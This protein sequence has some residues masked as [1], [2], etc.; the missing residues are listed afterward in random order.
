MISQCT[1]VES[2]ESVDGRSYN[3]FTSSS[4]HDEG[5]SSKGTYDAIYV[6]D[7]LGYESNNA[8]VLFTACTSDGDI[9]IRMNRHQFVVGGIAAGL[10]E[11]GK[12]EIT[13]MAFSEEYQANSL[14]L[15]VC[16]RHNVYV[17][18]I[19][20]M[21]NR[22]I[23]LQSPSLPATD[24]GNNNDRHTTLGTV[25][26]DAI[27]IEVFPSTSTGEVVGGSL[28]NVIS[29]CAWWHSRSCRNFALVG[30]DDKIIIVDLLLNLP[31]LSLSLPSPSSRISNIHVLQDR[32]PLTGDA[33][34]QS[35]IFTMDCEEGGGRQ[36]QTLL[37]FEVEGDKTFS[38]IDAPATGY[39][40]HHAVIELSNKFLVTQQV[41]SQGP[42]LSRLE[43]GSSNF[44]LFS[45]LH[46][47]NN[48]LYPLYEY[49]VPPEAEYV[50]RGK[51]FLFV[52]VP[53]KRMVDCCDIL[54]LSNYLALRNI[55][56]NC[57]LDMSQVVFQ[58]MEF[59]DSIVE[60][61]YILPT[62][63]SYPTTDEGRERESC[64]EEVS[65]VQEGGKIFVK[66]KSGAIHLIEEN[67]CSKVV[68]LGDI[69]RRG[70]LREAEQFA[71]SFGLDFHQC[72]SSLLSDGNHFIKSLL[73]DKAVA[74]LLQCPVVHL[75]QH[76]LVVHAF[77]PQLS[78]LSIY[79]LASFL[80][81]ALDIAAINISSP[82]KRM[83]LRLPSTP[84]YLATELLIKVLLYVSSRESSFFDALE[85]NPAEGTTTDTGG[86]LTN[87]LGKEALERVL[88]LC[89][90]DYRIDV[91]STL[92]CQYSNLTASAIAFEAHG[93]LFLGVKTR[94]SE[95]MI[96]RE[97]IDNMES[98]LLSLIRSHIVKLSAE[99]EIILSLCR[100]FVLWKRFNFP[101]GPLEQEILQHKEILGTYVTK[102]LLHNEDID[103]SLM[104]PNDVSDIKSLKAT[105]KFS[106]RFCFTL[107]QSSVRQ[108]TAARHASIHHIK[109]TILQ[110]GTGL[111]G[112][113][114]HDGNGVSANHVSITL[115]E[116]A[117]R[118]AVIFSCGH[119][120][121]CNDFKSYVLFEL[122]PFLKKQRV[123]T[124]ST[125]VIYTSY[126]EVLES[127]DAVVQPLSCPSCTVHLTNQLRGAP[128]V[129]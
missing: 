129:K 116:S 54:I 9:I 108:Y 39:I 103:Y 58:V 53:S 62:S 41:I 14:W 90:S 77:V 7:M 112:D 82:T 81:Q 113:G 55:L 19:L 122:V 106:K 109:D 48:P 12:E 15:L 35:M 86:Q 65:H 49:Q 87:I 56:P 10:T 30:S 105:L 110:D 73:P 2:V 18:P 79:N 32:S 71:L 74:V 102:F 5:V 111:V 36:F 26:A 125:N 37:E 120:F 66:T 46:P 70:S 20:D 98:V 38:S 31:I 92:T 4:Y 17:M 99:C 101:Y 91:V 128:I 97:G 85:C 40:N 69:V 27:C 118:Q 121:N 63:T 126:L 83:Q 72:L 80:A 44:A 127:N 24:G 8:P 75:W 34:W 45:I 96:G 84:K 107:V 94:L 78:P 29:S 21:V 47:Q 64:D 51:Q 76:I 3:I 119:T 16:T 117:L 89:A 1:P 59:N 42:V 68:M 6:Y 57:R 67:N 28:P 104:S 23:V 33:I 13:C 25:E 124:R 22:S 43:K 88:Q 61:R 115:P 52:V 93:W 95:V 11:G 123:T 100:V 114:S 50:V 60:L